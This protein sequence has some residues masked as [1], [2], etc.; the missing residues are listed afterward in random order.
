[1][2]KVGKRLL[3][4]I[5][6]ILLLLLC[7]QLFMM[8]G[9][10]SKPFGN[11][12][13]QRVDR[14][15]TPTLLIPGWGGGTPSYR[16]MI[17]VYQDKHIAQKTMTIWVFPNGK[18]IVKGH[19]DRQTP[20]QLIQLL[21]V[22]NYSSTYAPQT[23]QLTNVLTMLHQQYHVNKLNVI[24]HS[25]GGSEWANAVLR[26]PR[27]QRQIQYRRV[28]LLGVPVDETFGT[29]T[30][31]CFHLVHRSKDENFKQLLEGATKMQQNHNQPM[32]FNLMG[33]KSGHT[34]RTDGSVPHIQSEMTRVLVKRIDCPYYEHVY[35]N[36]THFQLHQKDE[37][38]ND[39]AHDIWG[40]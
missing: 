29:K 35:P 23:K 1:M 33:S 9:S 38:I 13:N 16:K 7:V 25:Y 3:S 19:L 26:S 40:Y 4:I 37:I 36:T 21:Y 34:T 5:G 14:S 8:S 12:I 18:T 32:I 39:V 22:W 15:T 30:H 11:Q 2:K 17:H 20:N 6:I 28:V 27:L 10:K 31:F 24:A